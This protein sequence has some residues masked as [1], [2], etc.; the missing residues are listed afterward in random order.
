MSNQYYE[1]MWEDFGRDKTSY[2]GYK[3]QPTYRIGLTNYLREF[4][5]FKFLDPQKTDVV[6]DCGCAAGKQLFDLSKSIKFGYGTDIAKNFIDMGNKYKDSHGIDNIILQQATI[7]NIPFDDNFFDKLI[8]AEV[9]E[10]VFDADLALRELIRVVKPGGVLV[11]SVPH[12]N[13]D[14]TLWGRLLRFLKVRKF[15][16]L[17]DFSEK[18]LREHGD[19]HVREFTKDSLSKW[20]SDNNLEIKDIKSASFIDGPNWFEWILKFLLH[21]SII[22]KSIIALEKQLT[23][24]NLFFGRQLIVKVIKK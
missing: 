16:P 12:I 13:A 19:A 8:C 11:I 23:N 7:E 14:A 4:F 6:L 21:V 9:L 20:L 3:Y 1:K 24:S 2:L 22:R 15:V 5:I 10:H 18:G 17:T